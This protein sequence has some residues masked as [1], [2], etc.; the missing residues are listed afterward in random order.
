MK[1]VTE[2]HYVPARR[3]TTTK[4]IAS[5]G[6]EFTTEEACLAHE[7]KL[8]VE[9]HPVFKNCVIG[10]LT[11]DNE[12]RG[13]LY[14]LS[15]DDDYEFLVKNLGLRRN[16]SINNDFYDYRRGWYLYWFENWGDYAD[17]HYIRN[18]NVYVEEIETELKEWKEEIQNKINQVNNIKYGR[19]IYWDGWKGNHDQRID[20]ATCSECGYEH[21][22]V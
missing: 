15:N 6:K 10:I 7:G 19:W 14:Y 12:H 22:T 17:H 18:Y 13:N 21:P 16:D 5:D 9:N 20:D 8:E 4:Y 1:V 2:K 11:F 3:Y